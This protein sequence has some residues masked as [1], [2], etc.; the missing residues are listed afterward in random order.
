MNDNTMTEKSED[1]PSAAELCQKY[2]RLVEWCAKKYKALDYEDAVQEGYVGLL[3]AAEH[4]NENAGVKFSTY[5]VY[6]IKQAILRAIY[7]SS[8]YAMNRTTQLHRMK[9][10]S[11]NYEAMTGSEP[12]DEALACMMGVNIAKA[13]DLRADLRLMQAIGLDSPVS[14]DQ[15]VSD[16]LGAED[17]AL[18][19]AERRTDSETM[20]AELWQLVDSLESVKRDLILSRFKYGKDNYEIAEELGWHIGRVSSAISRTLIE[21]RRKAAR[22]TIIKSYWAEYIHCI[23]YKGTGLT[24][25]K[26]TGWS[27]TEKAAVED[28]E[29]RYYHAGRWA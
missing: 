3:M 6:W 20:A 5:A 27:A 23:A 12:T 25:F 28:I 10:I 29:K 22:N 9:R 21:L 2:G 1:V 7:R 15:T 14:E 26:R 18:E 19:E 17:S 4:Y 13:K 16:L 11:S 24:S 8:G